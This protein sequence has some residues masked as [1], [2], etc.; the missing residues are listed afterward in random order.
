[1]TVFSMSDNNAFALFITVFTTL[2][3]TANDENDVIAI[4]NLTSFNE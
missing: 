4:A 3:V 1:M 2:L